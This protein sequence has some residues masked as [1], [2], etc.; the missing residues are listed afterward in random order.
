MDIYVEFGLSLWYTSPLALAIVA[1]SNHGLVIHCILDIEPQKSCMLVPGAEEVF[2]MYL[3]LF[4]FLGFVY[5]F[6][7]LSIFSISVTLSFF[8]VSV[9]F[10]V[11]TRCRECICAQ[12]CTVCSLA[13]GDKGGEVELV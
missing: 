8:D 6:I 13:L 5:L 4:Y 1:I 3:C 10:C 9:H 2:N 11:H 12:V 7:S